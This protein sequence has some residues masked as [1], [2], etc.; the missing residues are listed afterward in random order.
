MALPGNVTFIVDASFFLQ[1]QALVSAHLVI[2]VA[3][4]YAYASLISVV[5]SLLDDAFGETRFLKFVE[6]LN[7]T[8]FRLFLTANV[9]AVIYSG[10][11][12]YRMFLGY[13]T[14]FWS[15]VRISLIIIFA[16]ILF[17]SGKLRRRRLNL[18]F[19]SGA[20]RRDALGNSLSRVTSGIFNTATFTIM[21]FSVLMGIARARFVN[22]DIYQSVYMEGEVL[23]VDI[24]GISSNFVFG[25]EEGCRCSTLLQIGSISKIVTN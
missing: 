8:L 12:M 19:A 4:I 22:D 5:V 16:I 21:L 9:F 2:S 24:I 20:E 1:F 13:V 17:A 7:S 11:E 3:L 25:I 10:I 15:P 6:A 23:N 18:A 14:D